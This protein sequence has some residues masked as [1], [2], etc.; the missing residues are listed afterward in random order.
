[1]SLLYP[2]A[3]RAADHGKDKD[4]AA[5]APGGLS[6][7]SIYSANGYTPWVPT[8]T[9]DYYDFL[10]F[11]RWPVGGAEPGAFYVYG[12]GYVVITHFG[13]N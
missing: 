12:V 4:P 5:L 2:N 1:M 8:E 10:A 13:S 6:V 11:T 7:W 9:P 3:C